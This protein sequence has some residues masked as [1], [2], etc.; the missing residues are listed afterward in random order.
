M[1]QEQCRVAVR[2]PATRGQLTDLTLIERGLRVELEAVELAHERELGDLARIEMRRSS[3]RAI[4]CPM[5]NA[6]ASHR[7]IFERAFA[8][9]PLTIEKRVELVPDSREL[10]PIQHR[11]QRLMVDLRHH[12]PPPPRASYSASGRNRA[13]DGGGTVGSRLNAPLPTSPDR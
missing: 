13:G 1:P 9:M 2:N 3:R 4:F 6:S 12:Q 7:V 11:H 8:A 5:K 10:E